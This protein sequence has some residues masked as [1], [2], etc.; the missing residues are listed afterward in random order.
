MPYIEVILV[1][2]LILLNGLL[3]MSELAIA[4][5]RAVKLRAMVERNVNGARRA[6]ILASNPGRFLSTVQIGITLIGILAGAFSG[7]TLGGRVSD[8]FIILGVRENVAEPLGFGLVIG[9]ITYLSLIIGELVPKQIALRNPERIACLVAPAMTIL[10]KVSAP[11]V[12]LLEHSGRLVLMLLGQHRMKDSTVTDAEIHALIAEAESE[13]VLEPE[14]RTMIAGVMRLGD[15]LVRTIM[16]PAADVEM[17]DIDQTPAKIGKQMA[18][19]GH[20]RFIAYEKTRENIIGVL[21]A[22]DVAA[23]LLRRRAP[24]MRKLVKQAP[25]LPETLDALDVVNR[26]KESD[27]HFGL[28]YD[29]YGKFEGVVTTTDILEAIV[30]VFRH[31]ESEPEPDI[32][33]R[34]DGS[35]LVSGGTPIDLLSDRLGMSIPPTRDYQTVAG[36]ALDRLGRIPRPGDSFTEREY[37]FEIVDL[38]GRR[39]DKLIVTRTMP[40]KRRVA[41]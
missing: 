36:F 1:L 28:V 11:L 2:L 17:I 9:L 32:H 7:A 33:E 38:D 35:L 14:E 31:D 5:S 20:S 12:W 34:D 30:G 40:T 22:K 4:S 18:D 21:Q 39:I 24:Q 16:T 13:G 6:L 15:R 23:A 19:S 27:V 25:A 37:H 8:W 3:A 29:E 10:A 26:L 41:L